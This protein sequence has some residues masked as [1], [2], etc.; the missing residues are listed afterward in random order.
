VRERSREIGIRIAMG[1]DRTRVVGW[2]TGL[3]LRMILVGLV[4]GHGFAWALSGTLSELLFG[5]S[6]TDVSTLAAVV[7]LLVIVGLIASAIPSWRATRI[8]P[9]VILRG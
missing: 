7:G 3:G 1:A 5:V 9:A 6:P 8:D 4:V 2:V